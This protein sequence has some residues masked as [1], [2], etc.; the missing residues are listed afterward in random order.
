MGTIIEKTRRM[1]SPREGKECLPD[2][3]IAEIQGIIRHNSSPVSLSTPLDKLGFAVMD[4]ETTG[5]NYK[6]G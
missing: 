3:M 6:K 5:F 2:Y 1:F 4:V